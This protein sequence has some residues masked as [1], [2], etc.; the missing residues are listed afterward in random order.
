ME[1]VPTAPLFK[2]KETRA[3][4]PSYQ[5]PVTSASLPPFLGSWVVEGGPMRWAGR[6]PEPSHHHGPQV[7]E[8]PRAVRL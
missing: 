7:T 5:S 3:S 4:A 8:K 2:P 1:A 6:L